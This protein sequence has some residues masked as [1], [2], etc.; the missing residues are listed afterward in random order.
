MGHPWIHLP[1][2]ILSGLT[3]RERSFFDEIGSSV[4]SVEQAAQAEE[5]G[6]TYLVAGHIFSTDCKRG[7]PPRGLGFL[8]EICDSANVPVYGIGGITEENEK[9]VTEAGAEGVCVMSGCMQCTY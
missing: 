1:L 5:L 2:P 6:A 7:V 8:G 4:H 3:K 9:A